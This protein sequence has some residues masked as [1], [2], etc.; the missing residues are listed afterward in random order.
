MVALFF[1]RLELTVVPV[2]TTTGSVVPEDVHAAIRWVWSVVYGRTHTTHTALFP[3]HR[4][5]TVLVA[6][7]LANNETGIIMVGNCNMY[8]HTYVHRHTT[9]EHTNGHTNTHTH[10]HTHAH[11]HTHT[12]C[13]HS[14]TH[15]RAHTCSVSTYL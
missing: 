10:T 14:Y 9:H 15:M 6:V 13:I 4:P 2:R 12:T 7:M 3:S 8:T 5:N 11:A 1:P